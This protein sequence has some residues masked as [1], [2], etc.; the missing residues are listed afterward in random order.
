MFL[1]EASGPLFF[2]LRDGGILIL[3]ESFL[4]L[5]CKR[6]HNKNDM[7]KF[8]FE[9]EK[10]V[11]GKKILLMVLLILVLLLSCISGVLWHRD[12]YAVV[13]GQFYPKDVQRL[14]LREQEITLRHYE[15]LRRRLPECEIFW[16][17][18]F[19]NTTLAW[20][21]EEITVTTLAAG[22][23]KAL[24]YLEHLETVDGRN[25]TDY[26]N[27]LKLQQRRPEINVK[28]TIP[29][30]GEQYS[31]EA[32]QVTLSN[33]TAE[34]ISLL[35]YLPKLETVQC[36]GGEAEAIA[37]LQ[38]YCAD[39][40]LTF[41]I[42][43]GGEA[44]PPDT[45]EVTAGAITGEE[46]SL[47]QFLPEMK[48]LHVRQPKASAVQLLEWKGSR[49]DVTVTWEQAVGGKVLPW[50]TRELDLSGGKITDL[51]TLQQQLTY[52]PEAELVFLG[53][54]GLDNDKLADLRAQV[55]DQYKLVWTVSCGS[56]LKTRTDATTFMPV[57]EYVY[58]FN[59][60]E[61]YNL[62]YCEDM[63]CIDI[64]HMSIHNIDFVKF[65]PNLEYLI[66]AHTQVQYIEPISTCKKLKFLEL[67][68][69]PI[70]DLTPLKSCTALEDLNLG[71]TYAD[72]APV[73]EMTWL[74]N[75]WMVGCSSGARYRMT[76]ALPDTKV[77][78]TGAA[79]VANG[80][81]ELDNYYKMRDLLGMRYMSW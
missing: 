41:S 75:L 39:N 66:L 60:E 45:R 18:P 10:N 30:G 15:K 7:E 6:T 79:T 81:R 21:T 1:R 2:A 3:R 46:L 16:N 62:R 17:V 49:P 22:D 4:D 33:V 19:Q 47:L 56:K 76:Q 57:R 38:D 8:S 43:L 53:E 29:L 34:E 20:N 51:E 28:Y 9:G 42:L 25:C 58:Y 74:K 13:E 77:M 70:R 35:A 5:F 80:W 78:V 69:S 59:D 36:S 48:Q 52:F 65:M 37:G 67:D 12:H 73:G 26:E 11:S 63:V 61:A 32:T 68:W 24:E 44:I 27:L 64:G 50:D 14:D 54:C 31:G 72:F 71:N 23:L 55:R 40:Q